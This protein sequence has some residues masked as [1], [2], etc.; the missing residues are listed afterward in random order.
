LGALRPTGL[1]RPMSLE[2]VVSSALRCLWAT[3]ENEGASAG[4][5]PS[6][7][8]VVCPQICSMKSSPVRREHDPA[9]DKGQEICS[10]VRPDACHR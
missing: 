10:L 7:G 6:S 2:V 1:P 3:A 9:T 4:A 5:V 8:G